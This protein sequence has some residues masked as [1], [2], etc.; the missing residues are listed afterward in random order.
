M[1]RI[2]IPYLAV[3]LFL[4]LA[5]CSRNAAEETPDVTTPPST[6][7]PQT[8]ISVE[9]EII[10]LPGTTVPFPADTEPSTETKAE[11]DKATEFPYTILITRP[12]LMIYT[13]PTY[14][15]EDIGVLV[16][17]GLYTILSEK[18]DTEGTR[19]G[20]LK[21]GV[22]WI[23]L[24]TARKEAPHIPIT[25]EQATTYTLSG[26]TPYEFRLSTSLYVQRLLFRAQEK[27]TD[28]RVNAMDLGENGLE[29]GKELCSLAQLTPEK[30]LVLILNFPGDMTAYQIT[31][32]DAAGTKQHYIL[33]QSGRNG[34]ALLQEYRP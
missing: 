30:P 7:A 28:L 23:D 2:K 5:G 14:D 25:M 17:P 20:E 33:T 1:K 18:I 4:L 9:T 13:E 11:T 6:D 22:G 15:A 27:L 16:D 31:F 26:D 21:S 12:D 32:T 8:S 24:D 3:C 34:S 10:V 19:W 29:Q